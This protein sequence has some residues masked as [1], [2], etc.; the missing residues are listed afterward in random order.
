ML[1]K[2]WMKYFLK[3]NFIYFW[4]SFIALMNIIHLTL[5]LHE[6]EIKIK[7]KIGIIFN[8]SSGFVHKRT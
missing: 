1:E 6:L 3:S 5:I 4:K 7:E 8:G 2:N